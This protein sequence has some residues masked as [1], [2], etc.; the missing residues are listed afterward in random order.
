MGWKGGKLNNRTGDVLV[1]FWGQPVFPEGPSRVVVFWLRP[2]VGPSSIL[3]EE[4][5]N[6]SLIN[7]R[8]ILIDHHR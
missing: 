3:E 1:V 8:F 5:L 2:T 4:E 7:R 6:Q